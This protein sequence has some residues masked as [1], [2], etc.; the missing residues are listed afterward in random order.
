MLENL[1]FHRRNQ[2]HKFIIRIVKF[3]TQTTIKH[4]GGNA[5]NLFRNIRRRYIVVSIFGIAHFFLA[6]GFISRI[7]KQNCVM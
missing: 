3:L 2:S 7:Y 1:R 4:G 6:V 5:K